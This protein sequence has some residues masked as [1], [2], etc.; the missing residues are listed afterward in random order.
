V[1]LVD[2]RHGVGVGLALDTPIGQVEL[3]LG[4]SFFFRKDFLD[5]PLSLGPLLGYFSIGYSI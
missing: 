5:Y 3:S 4:Q 2:L 1:R